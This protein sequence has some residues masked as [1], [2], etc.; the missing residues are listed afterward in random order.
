[1]QKVLNLLGEELYTRPQVGSYTIKTFEEIFDS[2]D[3]EAISS[4]EIALF[5]EKLG[6]HCK[7]I[8]SSP[9]A[10]F[11]MILL[12]IRSKLEYMQEV[13]ALFQILNL[14]KKQSVVLFLA[15]EFIKRDASKALLTILVAL[16]EKNDTV[17]S[18]EEL[19]DIYEKLL[20]ESPSDPMILYKVATIK[21]KL[22]KP[23]EALL[24]YKAAAFNMIN[25][26][27]EFQ[28]E[29]M[30]IWETFF[31]LQEA[32]FDFFLRSM[33]FLHKDFS[34]EKLESAFKSLYEYIMQ[35]SFTEDQKIILIKEMFHRKCP[36]DWDFRSILV[37]RYKQKYRE[38]TLLN[39]FIEISR[40]F[41]DD[42][43]LQVKIDNFESL[44][45]FD[46]GAYVFHKSFGYG[47]IQEVIV[48]DK[49]KNS[50]DFKIDFEKKQSHMMSLRIATT[51]L[52]VF[53]QKDFLIQK[54]FEKQKLQKLLQENLQQFLEIIFQS[55]KGGLTLLQMKALLCPEIISL[56]NW[57][58]Q[59]KRIQK[60]LQNSV[61]IELR[62]KTYIIQSHKQDQGT[63]LL[64]RI[65]K[66]IL[67]DTKLSLMETL[68]TLYVVADKE[69]A[70]LQQE[71]QTA[72]LQ[73][74]K[75]VSCYVLFR[76]IKLKERFSLQGDF[77]D[78]KSLS[79]IFWTDEQI[80]E[81]I[82]KFLGTTRV[83]FLQF[84]FAKV[85]KEK[86]QQLQR[87]FY[88]NCEENLQI[89]HALLEI[90]TSISKKNT[91]FLKDWK[92][93]LREL[94]ENYLEKSD[95]F[96]VF[97]KFFLEKS[98][99][100]FSTI[101]YSN[102]ILQ[103]VELLG[104]FHKEVEFSGKQSRAKKQYSSVF[105]MLF[106][107]DKLIS[108]LQSKESQ[109]IRGVIIKLLDQ[110]HFLE[111]YIKVEIKKLAIEFSVK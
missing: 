8:S 5:L 37:E 47:K 11:A 48:S 34:V 31:V 43:D 10:L 24:Y 2:T 50:A 17:S 104:I 75:N 35:G 30:E 110:F 89:A 87:L 77:G 79:E 95:A 22:N 71:M 57:L 85:T 32:D 109:D 51:S 19:Q 3:F 80:Q 83:H 92:N 1:M 36:K 103:L 41:Q 12:K 6:E 58:P 49:D 4:E 72:L 23:M 108:F 76:V 42:G 78:E 106:D 96:I 105:S 13:H 111:N 15:R 60:Y 59:S 52:S 28:K 46:V 93:F 64:Q 14:A 21:R 102:V 55:S 107:Q 7:R 40:F 33:K 29:L 99:Q 86:Y 101:S 88:K 18:Q 38:N 16:V 73:E 39:T 44:I 66:E 9:I 53:D 74:Q 62:G 25:N 45:R 61:H 82:E 90:G 69:R 84:I 70:I 68:S 65:Q 27:G 20:Q 56:E 26:N 54:I 81:G 100:V 67:L 98:H 97:C 63:A 91:E 94:H